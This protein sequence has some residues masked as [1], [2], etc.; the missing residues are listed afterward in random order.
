MWNQHRVN[1]LI[2]SYTNRVSQ[3][4]DSEKSDVKAAAE[5][6]NNVLAGIPSD[7]S[8]DHDSY[9]ALLDVDGSGI[10][11]YLEIPKIDVRLPI[12]HDTGE[13]A[14]ENGVGHLE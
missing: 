3:M 12:F 5:A 4:Q 1:R 11:G 6:Y 13:A 7:A 9:N 10:M 2:E 8:T 14:P